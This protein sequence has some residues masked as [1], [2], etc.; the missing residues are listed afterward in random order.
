VAATGRFALTAE[1]PCVNV[2]G[3]YRAQLFTPDVADRRAFRFWSGAN[4]PKD[5][6]R[7]AFGS[8]ARGVL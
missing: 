6:L 1:E 8:M 4:C 5:G 2:V 3:S 7:G